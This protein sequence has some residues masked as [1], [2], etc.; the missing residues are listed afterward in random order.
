M[1][2]PEDKLAVRERLGQAKEEVEELNDSAFAK[3]A[4]RAFGI[5]EVSAKAAATRDLPGLKVQVHLTAGVLKV[6]YD[7]NYTGEDLEK[8]RG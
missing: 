6:I 7:V 1:R 8:L 5:V 4:G 3:L 2:K